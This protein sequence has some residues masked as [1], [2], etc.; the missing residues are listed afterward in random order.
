MPLNIYLDYAATTPVHPQVLEAMMP[1]F[2]EE[3]GNPS[4]LH[5]KGQS[6]RRAVDTA[7]RQCAAAL[8]SAPREILFT[9]GGT[10]SDNL[11]L[12]GVTEGVES[13]HIISVKT[14]HEA[15]LEPLKKL[16]K[17]GAQVTLLNVDSQGLIDLEEL[18]AALTPQTTL[19]TVMWANNE[20]GVIQDIP[21]IATL[22]QDYKKELGR[23]AKQPPFLHTDA[24]QA[25]GAL[26][27]SLSAAGVDLLTLNGS[28]IYGP[29]GVGLL[30]VRK[31]V[32]LSPQI[33]GGG[34]EHHRRSGTS[35]VPGIVGLA[36]ALE[37]ANAEREIEATRLTSLRDAFIKKVNT[38]LEGISLNGHPILR[39]PNN[40]NLTVQGIEGEILLMRLDQAGIYAS[41]GSACTAG[42]AEPSHVLLALGRSKQEAF[43]AVRFSLGKSTTAENLN[44][45]A[46]EFIK[47]VNE[48]RAESGR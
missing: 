26:D 45:V 33:V 18:R 22:I 12:F 39:L 5:T 43:G 20:I 44:K 46:D 6:A 4:S 27:L 13:P 24:C 29:K 48:L 47:I 28:K 9:S 25:A 8:N 15:V 40:I 36:K 16:E 14:E 11:A 17:K 35:N 2:V 37:L 1:Y 7:R 42:N 32:P 3:F 38:E 21:A 19:V 34:Q 10:E 30:Y 41:A 23:T 31:G